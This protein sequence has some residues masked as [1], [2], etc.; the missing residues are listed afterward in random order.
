MDHEINPQPVLQVVA[1]DFG[2]PRL[3]SV[4]TVII[5]V[6]DLND[7]APKFVNSTYRVT[8]SEDADVQSCFLQVRL[9]LIQQDIFHLLIISSRKYVGC[10]D[11]PYL[12]GL[13]AVKIN[14]D[15]E[16]K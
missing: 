9:K 12:F 3:S 11:K 16:C 1:T 15:Y 13:S 8:V 7:S 2:T 5:T 14:R 6:G 10:H 4:T